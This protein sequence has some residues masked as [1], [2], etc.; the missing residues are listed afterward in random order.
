MQESGDR[1]D[2]APKFSDA[3]DKKDAAHCQT[4]EERGVRG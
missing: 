4:H 2:A 3:V 1:G